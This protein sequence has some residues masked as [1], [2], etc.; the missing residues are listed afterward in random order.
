MSYKKAMHIL[1]IDLLE[2]I[3]AYVDGE[4]IYIPRKSGNKREWGT[5]TSTRKELQQRDIQ[6]YKDYLA[7]SSLMKLAE[8]YFLSVK[9]IQRI[10]RTQ[11]NMN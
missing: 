8:K 2:Q 1:P 5:E 9:S 10:I 3:Q 6:I 7:G 11:R 4:L